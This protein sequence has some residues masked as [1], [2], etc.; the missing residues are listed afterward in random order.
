MTSC[1]RVVCNFVVE[2]ICYAK[3]YAQTLG[4]IDIKLCYTSYPKEKIDQDLKT[5]LC[6]SQVKID[7]NDPM[8]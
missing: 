3:D 8:V 5:E 2:F 1:C 6:V 7:Y 4:E